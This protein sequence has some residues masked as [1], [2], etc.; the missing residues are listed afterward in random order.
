[1]PP[2]KTIAR[3]SGPALVAITLTEAYNRE[4]FIGNPATTIYLNGTVLFV[5]GLAIVQAHNVW[6]LRPAIL[7][8]ALGWSTMSLGLTRMVFPEQRLK[9]VAEGGWDF[10]A[11]L[12]ALSLAGVA[13]SL[14]GY[15]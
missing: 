7:V 5:A 2:T 10:Y 1:M 4:I 12:G 15:S 14:I 9:A 8:T 3:I 11:G 6:N 13:V